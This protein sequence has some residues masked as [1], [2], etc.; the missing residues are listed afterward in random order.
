M[1][2]RC[3]GADGVVGDD[4]ATADGGA[5][6]AQL[7]QLERPVMQDGRPAGRGAISHGPDMVSIFSQHPSPGRPPADV[8]SVTFGAPAGAHPARAAPSVAA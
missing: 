5:G 8:A 2:Q 3:L 6:R 4:R 7:R 1:R